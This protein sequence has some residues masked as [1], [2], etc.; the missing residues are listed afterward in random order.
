MAVAS[1][2]K[3][4]SIFGP[5][6]QNIY[7]P[8]LKD[9]RHLVVTKDVDCR[10]CYKKFKIPECK[11]LKCLEGL[12]VDEVFSAVTEHMAELRRDVKAKTR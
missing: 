12:N 2:A 9:N 3:T 10:P 7:G 6:D 4:V 5:S 11:N 8:Y 1:G